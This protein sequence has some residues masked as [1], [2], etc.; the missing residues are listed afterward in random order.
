MRNKSRLA[1][2]HVTRPR[3][4]GR[5]GSWVQLLR[6][7]KYYDIQTTVQ[8]LR[9]SNIRHISTVCQA[10]HNAFRTPAEIDGLP[11][12]SKAP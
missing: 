5:R 3:Q 10:Q 1:A 6:H 8:L 11:E 12:I 7:S 2:D 9:H 4:E